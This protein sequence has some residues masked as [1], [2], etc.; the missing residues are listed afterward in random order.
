MLGNDRE[1]WR[2]RYIYS[3][4]MQ[5]LMKKTLFP[6]P[7]ETAKLMDLSGLQQPGSVY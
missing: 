7:L 1:P 6:F 5:I 3:L 4:N 2:S